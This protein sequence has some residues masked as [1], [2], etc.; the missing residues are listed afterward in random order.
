MK[1]LS[2]ILP[3]SGEY[4]IFG[5]SDH[6]VGGFSSDS[7]E[8]GS[9]VMFV[10]RKGLVVDGHAFIP[11][12]IEKGVKVIL[13]KSCRLKLKQMSVMFDVLICLTR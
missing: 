6:T 7:R 9:G 1:S 2:Q 3:Q 10:A 11:E 13:V 12:V 4:Q 8:V 5:T